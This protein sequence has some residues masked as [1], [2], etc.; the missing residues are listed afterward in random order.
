MPTVAGV[1][2]GIKSAHVAPKETGGVVIYLRVPD[3]HLQRPIFDLLKQNRLW[4]R[5][6]VHDPEE[7]AHNN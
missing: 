6:L 3:F 4:P 1:D 7:F 5:P 2:L